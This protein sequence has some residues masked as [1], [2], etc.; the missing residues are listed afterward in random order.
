MSHWARES[1][2]V[3][4]S[5]GGA[6]TYYMTVTSTDKTVTTSP[7]KT[8]QFWGVLLVNTDLTGAGTVTITGEDSGMPLL[9][10]TVTVLDGVLKPIHV[11]SESNLDGTTNIGTNESAPLINERLKIVFAG[12]GVSKTGVLDVVFEG[13]HPMT[14]ATAT[15]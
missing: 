1:V 11:Q 3:T 9:V 5:A 13:E 7:S 8:T 14:V 6:A 10:A 15:S 12:G 2:A 4:V